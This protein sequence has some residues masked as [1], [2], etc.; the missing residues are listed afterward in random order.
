VAA[1]EP[2]QTPRNRRAT[3]A[4]AALRVGLD[5]T[6]RDWQ[7]LS[8]AGAPPPSFDRAGVECPRGLALA[9]TQPHGCGPVPTFGRGLRDWPN[10]RLLPQRRRI[11]PMDFTIY[12]LLIIAAFI[13]VVIWAFGRKR[14]KRFEKDAKIPFEGDQR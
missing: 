6:P 1:L 7:S 12:H 4:S 9:L 8:A 11:G 5:N 14:K 10:V 13:G 2:S 3:A